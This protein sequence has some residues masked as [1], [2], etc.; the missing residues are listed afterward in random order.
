MPQDFVFVWNDLLLGLT[1]L[2]QEHQP[3]T[4]GI[5][6]LQPPLVL[7]VV[8]NRFNMRGLFAGSVK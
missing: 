3:L 6:N 5:A 1:L 4:V 2:D 8:L 7:F